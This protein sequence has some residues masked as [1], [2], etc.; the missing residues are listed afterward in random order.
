MRIDNFELSEPIPHLKAPHAVAM[1]RPWVDCGSVGTLVLRRLETRFGSSELARLT[2]PG[3]FYDF[4]RYRPIT[5][6]KGGVRQLTIPN[7][8]IS[9]ARN[10]TG[11][12]FVFLHLLEPHMLGEIYASSVWQ[13]LKKLE[14]RRYCL[15]GSFY[16]MVPH[17][18]PILV[19]GGTS[20]KISQANLE[21]IGVRQSNYEGPTSICN[22]ISQEAE[23]TGVETMTFMVHLPHYTELEEDYMGTI[24]LL[25]VLYSLYDI[26][27][28]DSDM[29]LAE[30]QVKSLD[31]AVQK[32]RKLKA[33]VT[34]LETQYDARTASPK[35]AEEPQLSPEV[36]KFLKEMEN[37]FRDS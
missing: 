35:D 4:T 15:I 5:H 34:Q 12:D 14:I 17:T 8:T 25:K 30:G 37:R 32:D 18:R 21:K 7:T 6:F 28:S 27:M 36:D 19:S 24:A 3:S 2:Q 22:L 26:P 29:R 31:A 9:W 13:V 23:K 20:S 33:L 1:L 11:N 16:D 10:D